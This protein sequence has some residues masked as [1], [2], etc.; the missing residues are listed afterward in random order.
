MYCRE[1]Q[2]LVHVFIYIYKERLFQE[3]QITNNRFVLFVLKAD[4]IPFSPSRSLNLKFQ[5][6]V[7]IILPFLIVGL[8]DKKNI[9][10]IQMEKIS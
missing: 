6:R 3:I 1:K 4:A 7:V 9:L 8:Y 2:E 10:S 5:H